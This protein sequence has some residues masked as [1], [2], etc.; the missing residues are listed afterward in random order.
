VGGNR[1]RESKVDNRM[2]RTQDIHWRTDVYIL[3]AVACVGEN[4]VKSVSFDMSWLV[5]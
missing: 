5:N 2:I 3:N 4:E 1:A